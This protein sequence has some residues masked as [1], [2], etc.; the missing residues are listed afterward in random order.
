[1]GE[2]V[3]FKERPDKEHLPVNDDLYKFKFPKIF[4][5]MAKVPKPQKELKRM[6]KEEQIGDDT[7]T[8]STFRLDGSSPIKLS[9]SNIKTLNNYQMRENGFNKS[10]NFLRT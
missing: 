3:K 1:M 2:S 8:K 5:F 4:E 10:H 7:A 6:I 9:Q